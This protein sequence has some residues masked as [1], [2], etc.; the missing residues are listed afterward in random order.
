MPKQGF[1]TRDNIELVTAANVKI[2]TENGNFLVSKYDAG[3]TI[4]EG[5]G[6]ISPDTQP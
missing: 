1:F 6:E 2:V 3:S 4:P 5:G